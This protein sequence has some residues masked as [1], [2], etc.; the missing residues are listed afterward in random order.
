MQQALVSGST[1]GIGKSVTKM[2]LKLGYE[3]VGLSRQEPAQKPKGYTHIEVDLSKEK[4][5]FKVAEQLKNRHFDVVV[6]N[7]G[8]GMFRPHEELSGSQIY[9]MVMLNLTAPLILAKAT[10]PSLKKRGG[11]LFNIT[12]IEAVRS[13][14]FSASYSATKSGL[15]AFGDVLFEESRKTDL[16]V[17]NII[18]DMTETNFFDN[19]GFGVTDKTSQKLFA[20]D[21]ADAIEHIL[22]LRDG[23]VVQNYMVRSLHFGIA[24]GKQN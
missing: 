20:Q 16:H 6:N 13:S 12:S 22:G 5:L 18:P 17:C 10:L 21:I 4:E 14:K 2:L 23:I 1:K 15:K 7:A 19:L 9:S 11:Y 8:F 24:K 3:V